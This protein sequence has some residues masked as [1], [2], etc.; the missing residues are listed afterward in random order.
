MRALIPGP[1]PAGSLRLDELPE[2]AADA[3]QGRAEAGPGGGARRHLPHR[4]RVH[5]LARGRRAGVSGRAPGSIVCL[6]GLGGGEHTAATLN[7]SMVLEHRV[8]VGTV[9]A[10]LRHYQQAAEALSRAKQFVAK[11]AT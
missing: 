4:H 11:A 1:G 6:K 5:R 3:T 9:S 2:P 10:N 7:R 8:V